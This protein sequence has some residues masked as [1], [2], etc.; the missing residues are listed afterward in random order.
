M[1]I[2]RIIQQVQHQAQVL[3]SEWQDEQHKSIDR[4]LQQPVI[5]GSLNCHNT[6]V[7]ALC[8]QHCDH[9]YLDTDDAVFLEQLYLQLLGR[10][11]D[12]T[13][14][15]DYGN[16]LAQGTPR[17]LI[18]LSLLRSSERKPDVGLTGTL[19][20]KPFW[21]LDKILKK[22]PKTNSVRRLLYK[23]IYLWERSRKDF[24]Q[25][26]KRVQ[27]QL[28]VQQQAIAT[29]CQHQQMHHAS[30]LAQLATVVSQIT[31]SQVM[32][33]G[34]EQ[35]FHLLQHKLNYHQ[36][37]LE[38]LIDELAQPSHQVASVPTMQAHTQDRLDAYYVAF[39]DFNR[40]TR[41]QIRHKLSPYLNIVQQRG[42][43]DSRLSRLP[44]LDIGCGRG[45]WLHLLRE[46]HLLAT[47][48]DM[49]PVM[50]DTCQQTGLDVRH[51]D[52]LTWLR[53]QADNSH[54][55]ITGFHIIEH[56]PFEV[57]FDL[58]AESYR[59]LAPN[60]IMIFE[61]PNPENLLVASHTFYH[62]FTHK[63]PITPTAISFLAKYH[64][65][66]EIDILRLHPYPSEARVAGHDALTERVNGHLTGPQDFAILAIKPARDEQRAGV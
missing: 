36:H 63:N 52:A 51:S 54:A 18:A 39:E 19:W 3:A 40:G 13:G 20:L 31:T 21:L 11:I 22:L 64:N 59:V 25:P 15:T 43:V 29:V 12:E 50:V 62:D 45:E 26:I 35:D 33:H 61:T 47:G 6:D 58:F 60:G 34:V 10:P 57:L 37:A 46:H 8:W 1:S 56:L 5:V 9:L 17:V 48:V 23:P 32:V 30:T 55:A 41:E 65:F 49:N 24:W 66:A 14:A 4:Q 27:T 38:R 28:N 44:L 7:A 42:Q 2:E 16:Q 53:A